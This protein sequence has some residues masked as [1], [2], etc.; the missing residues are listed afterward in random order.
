MSKFV[1]APVAAARYIKGRTNTALTH[2]VELDASE[3]PARVL[4]GKVLV[5]SVLDDSALYGAPAAA[6]CPACQ[7]A[8]ARTA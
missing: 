6:T 2:I 4:C 7:R 8:A 3:S 5:S 1:C